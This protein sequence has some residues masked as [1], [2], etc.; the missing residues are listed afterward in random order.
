MSEDTIPCPQCQEPMPK[1]FPE[2]PACGASVRA[3]AQ[4]GEGRARA[5]GETGAPGEAA[6]RLLLLEKGR[7]AAELL[8]VTLPAIPR[9]VEARIRKSPDREWLELLDE[10]EKESRAKT[11]AALTEWEKRT[12][13][14]LQ[15]L[16]AYS[17]DGRLE[18]EQVEDALSAARAGETGRALSV[19][20]QVDR[21]IAL[22]ERHVDVARQ[23]LGRLTDLVRD[24]RTLGISVSYDPKELSEELEQELRR[25]RLAPLKQQLRA[26]RLDVVRSLRSTFPSYVARVGGALEKE[27]SNGADAAPRIAELAR[28]AKAY[29][30]GRPDEAVRRLRLLAERG[31]VPG[32]T[33]GNARRGTSGPTGPSRT[34]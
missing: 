22:K 3:P 16:E 10:V 9:W 1:G 31:A 15:H 4:G 30:E 25:G 20:Q 12:L 27:R 8:G 29:A 23:E 14:R 11:L 33:G 7:T 18:R 17:I 34:A 13:G 6:E 28:S 24:L 2:C 5:H 32:P 19:V 21:V 26:L